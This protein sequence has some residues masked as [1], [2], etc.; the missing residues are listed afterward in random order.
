M[1][2]WVSR[3]Y[4][5]VLGEDAEVRDAGEALGEEDAFQV[6][7]VHDRGGVLVV[8]D[9][10]E[11]ADVGVVVAVA[12]GLEDGLG[13][14]D[15]QVAEAGDDQVDLAGREALVRVDGG[16]EGLGEQRVR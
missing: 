15:H 1:L 6:G 16:F 14:D 9:A 5:D 7:L 12:G 8:F 3:G 2:R 11:A 13:D 10:G 4:A